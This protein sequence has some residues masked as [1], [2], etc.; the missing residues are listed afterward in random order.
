MSETQVQP[1]DQVRLKSG[2]PALTVRQIIPNDQGT[3][4]HCDWFDKGKAM[5]D[6]FVLES[7]ERA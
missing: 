6:V 5:H 1:G 4:V 7:L 3:F 2:G